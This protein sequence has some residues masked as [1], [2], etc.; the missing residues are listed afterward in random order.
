MTKEALRV[1]KTLPN[2]KLNNRTLKEILSYE[3]VSL[4][5]FTELFLFLRLNELLKNINRKSKNFELF[6]SV[7]VK[8][9]ILAKTLL[10]S[11]LGY[12]F[13]LRHKNTRRTEYIPKILAVS[14]SMHWHNV[15][16]P[17]FKTQKDDVMLGNIINELITRNKK[18]VALDQDSSLFIDIKTLVEKA[19]YKK[20]L[21]KPVEVYLTLAIIK[22][23]LSTYSEFRKEIKE[24][25]RD[26]HLPFSDPLKDDVLISIRYHIFYAL[27][28]IEL[29]KHAIETE[30]PDLI[31]IICE[32]CL[33]GRAAVVAGKLKGVPTLAIQHGNISPYSIGYYHPAEEVSDEFALRYCP[34][35]D[36]TA[37]YGEYTKKI[38]TE[39]GNYTADKVVVTGSSRYDLIARAD[40]I[41]NR[42]E[43]RKMLNL[44]LTK[45][46]AL[47]T[48]ENLPIVEEN[49]LFLR[50]IL[51]ALK[52]LPEVQVVIKP[53]PGEKSKWYEQIV[54]EEKVKAEI[55]P[56]NSDTFEALYACDLLITCFST[57][58]TEAMI[59]NKPVIT[60]N[61]TGATDPMPYAES[62]V[63][64]GVY[65][66]EDISHAIR[67]ALYNEELRQ[68]LAI[69]M[70][71]FVYEHAYKQDG[72][73]TE[74]V[75]DLIH[76]M[77]EES[78][79]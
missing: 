70:K 47:V 39:V 68:R 37:V 61:L 25:E 15:T 54:K 78:K 22:K 51:Q 8:Y 52:E 32:Y 44:T 65:K 14:Y 76:E 19:I 12:L 33:L 46:I 41:Y 5:W 67:D 29:M 64:I 53:H 36:K 72:K 7:F 66:E 75:A 31:L 40:E 60:V 18:V 57:V 63:A 58:A 35:P 26:E 38:L 55:L 6:L 34:I 50:S 56:K 30:K 24:L 73:A 28:Y 62:G 21:W 10:R 59:L 27:L 79:R 23:V 43:F 71:K 77:I 13:C 45:T 9:Y 4:W 1:I 74:R 17:G 3:N 42:E 49:I 11:F 2:T 20:G 16:T 48:T 69:N